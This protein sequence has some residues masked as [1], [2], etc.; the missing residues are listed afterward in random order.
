MLK[1]IRVVLDILLSGVFAFGAFITLL[2]MIGEVLGIPKLEM[3]LLH[4]GISSYDVLLHIS[5]ILTPM[6]IVVYVLRQMIIKES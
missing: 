5:Y 1:C 3:L 4:L 6:L 2:Y